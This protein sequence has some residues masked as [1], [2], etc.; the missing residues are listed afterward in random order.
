MTVSTPLL[1]RAIALALSASALLL[2][3]PHSTTPPKVVS[4]SIYSPETPGSARNWA[5]TADV[6]AASVMASPVVS[7]FSPMS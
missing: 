6:I 2:T 1:W 5:F 4:T 3:L 7:T